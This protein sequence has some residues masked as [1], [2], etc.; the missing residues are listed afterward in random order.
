MLCSLT[1]FTQGNGD[2]SPLEMDQ[3]VFAAVQSSK[4]TQVEGCIRMYEEIHRLKAQ[5]KTNPDRTKSPPGC[6]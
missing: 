1:D 5:V 2:H 6:L 4:L 3:E